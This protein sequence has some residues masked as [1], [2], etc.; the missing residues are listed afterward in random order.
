MW[1]IWRKQSE[2]RTEIIRSSLEEL[3]VTGGDHWKEC[4]NRRRDLERA[5]RWAKRK[6]YYG[7]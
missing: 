3:G 4:K 2:L 6:K 5:G 7:A 1:L